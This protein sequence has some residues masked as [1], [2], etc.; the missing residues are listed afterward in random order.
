V[1][2]VVLPSSIARASGLGARLLVDWEPEIFVRMPWVAPKRVSVPCRPTAKVSPDELGSRLLMAA[3]LECR[4]A[5][6]LQLRLADS[7][8]NWRTQITDQEPSRV[9]VTPLAGTS[10]LGLCGR[11]LETLERRGGQG[12]KKLLRDMM[13]DFN[14]E[15][16]IYQVEAELAALGYMRAQATPRWRPAPEVQRFVGDCEQIRTLG[17]E[18]AQAVERWRR[19]ILADQKLCDALLADCTDSITRPQEQW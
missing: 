4:D 11:I 10:G 5:G 18:R 12:A 2:A 3:L 8:R 16:V 17:Q 15:W 13:G 1:A 19:V 7:S 6:Q 9:W 14:E